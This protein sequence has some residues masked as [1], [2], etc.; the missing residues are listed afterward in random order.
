M[1]KVTY[2]YSKTAQFIS[3]EEVELIKAQTEA[4][5]ELLLSRKGAGMISSAGSI[6]L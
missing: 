3:D 6:F 5:R 4:A 1:S 2:D